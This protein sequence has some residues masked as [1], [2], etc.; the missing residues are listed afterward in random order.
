MK[1][2]VL[3]V[4][5]TGNFPKINNGDQSV[6]HLCVTGYCQKQQE[7]LTTLDLKNKF[8]KRVSDILKF[9]KASESIIIATQ[10]L[11]DILRK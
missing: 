10:V 9:L 8:F 2:F 4:E 5:S 1:E 7:L 11:Y 6:H 3:H